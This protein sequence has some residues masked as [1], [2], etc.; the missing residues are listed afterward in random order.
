MTAKLKIRM[1]IGFNWNVLEIDAN[2]QSTP[3]RFSKFSDADKA[4][5]MEMMAKDDTTF[6]VALARGPVTVTDATV[7]LEGG[8][9]L[10]SSSLVLGAPVK[11]EV[12]TSLPPP[13]GDVTFEITATGTGDD[14]SQ[15]KTTTQSA[16]VKVK[17]SN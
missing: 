11:V 10:P 1:G 2:G 17:R 9:S 14:G 7:E 16:Y 4:F 15:K 5:E 13:G 12:S 3:K 6:E 8:I